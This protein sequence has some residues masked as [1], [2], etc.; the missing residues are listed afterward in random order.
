M[1]ITAWIHD[2]P[3]ATGGLVLA[4]IVL[5]IIVRSGSSN[6]TGGTIVQGPSD[7]QVAAGTQLQA[8]QLA[9]QQATVQTNAAASVAGAQIQ[10]QQA[11]SSQQIDA[12]L[13]ATQIAADSANQISTLQAQV[14]MAPYNLRK[15]EDDLYYAHLPTDQALA[16]LQ[17][18]VD[19]NAIIAY[20]NT[21]A[22]QGATGNT[23]WGL[24]TGNVLIKPDGGTVLTNQVGGGTGTVYYSPPVT[25]TTAATRNYTA[26]LPPAA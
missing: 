23:V 10:A 26:Y 16:A 7:A 19:S 22:V 12:Q 24:G 1:K 13:K 4:A 20:N 2:H 17:S 18:Q 5:F 6:N 21:V 9:A 11:I 15:Y 8:A 3:Y 14:A 25:T